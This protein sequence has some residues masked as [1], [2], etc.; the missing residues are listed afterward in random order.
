MDFMRTRSDGG[1]LSKQQF[2]GTQDEEK[3]EKINILKID[4]L[5]VKETS[6]LLHLRHI[7]YRENAKTR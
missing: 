6:N 1:A 3:P 7:K 2:T 4:L 5:A